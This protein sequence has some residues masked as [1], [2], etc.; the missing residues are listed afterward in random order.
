MPKALNINCASCG[1][2]Q[3]E[4]CCYSSIET[5]SVDG[6]SGN[7]RKKTLHAPRFAKTESVSSEEDP[8]DVTGLSGQKRV[9]RVVYDDSG[10]DADVESKAEIDFTTSTKRS[11]KGPGPRKGMS[12][13]ATRQSS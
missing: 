2:L 5:N 10:H 9:E 11:Q 4:C 8:D 12:G 1:Q 7:A 13:S 6:E 3:S